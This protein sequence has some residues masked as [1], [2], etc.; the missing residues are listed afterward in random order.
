MGEVSETQA[1]NMNEKANR[2]IVNAE[3]QEPDDDNQP[4]AENDGLNIMSCV[5]DVWSRG[6]QLALK[7]NVAEMRQ[8]QLK[9]QYRKRIKL[10][11][12][13]LKAESATVEKQDLQ[14]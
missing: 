6:K 8:G 2:E 12:C 9:I 11:D 4:N 7:D 3:L 5:I 1:S 14:S 13:T 10:L